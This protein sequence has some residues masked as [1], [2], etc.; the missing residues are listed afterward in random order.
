MAFRGKNQMKDIVIIL[1]IIIG[2]ILLIVGKKGQTHKHVKIIGIIIIV[3][4]LGMVIP[5][6]IKGFIDGVSG[7]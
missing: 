3:V 1:G 4:C 2:G 5:D 6:F 7:K